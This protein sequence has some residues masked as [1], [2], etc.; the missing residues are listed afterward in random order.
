[1]FMPRFLTSE[2]MEALKFAIGLSH[3]LS[4][5]DCDEGD[6]IGRHFLVPGTN[7]MYYDTGEQSVCYAWILGDE[8]SFCEHFVHEETHRVLHA[9]I[10]LRSCC[11]YDN[12]ARYAEAVETEQMTHTEEISVMVLDETRATL[13]RV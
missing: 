7:F 11:D 12:V 2:E 9:L 4:V 1:M 6:E 5:E 10:G 3:G 13:R 8:E